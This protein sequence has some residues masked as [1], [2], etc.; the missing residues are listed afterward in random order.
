MFLVTAFNVFDRMSSDQLPVGGTVTNSRSV[1]VVCAG[2]AT[3]VV[4]A[5]AAK[6]HV[7]GFA[8]PNA[9]AVPQRD[10]G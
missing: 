7:E 10:I 6:Q 9:V 8:C 2:I 5:L 4:P 3:T 1:D